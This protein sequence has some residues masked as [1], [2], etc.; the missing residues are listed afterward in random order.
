MEIF[1]TTPES[2]KKVAMCHRRAFPRSL[3]SRLGTAYCIKM[4]SWYVEDERGDMFHIEENGVVAGYCG[5]IL[6]REPGC[7]GSATS[8][9]QYSFRAL[10]KAFLLRPWL[11]FHPEMLRRLP[12]I[13]RNLK[14]KLGIGGK[15]APVSETATPFRPSMGLVVIGV[16]P[17]LQGRGYG[18]A[19]LSEFERR[20]RA[21]EFSMV[22]LSVRC[23]NTQAIS[24]YRR[25]GWNPGKTHGGEVE[26]FKTLE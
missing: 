3:A 19:L 26:M 4:L 23:N 25:N 20:A 18:S 10:V 21:W 14:L 16:D 8:I 11:I 13:I 5:S 9:T 17:Q 1:L 7:H 6:R 22:Y 2:I 15:P 24:A 12:F